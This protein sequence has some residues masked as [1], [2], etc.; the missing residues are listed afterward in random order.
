MS[1][2]STCDTDWETLQGLVLAGGIGTRLRPFTYTGAKQLLPVANKPVLFYGIEQLVAADVRDIGIIVGGAEA[3]VRALVGNGD[4]FGAQVTYLPQRDPLG[5]AHA[6]AVARAWLGQ[7]P[8][9][10]LLGDNFLRGGLKAIVD[11]F[12]SVRPVAQ[13][14]LVQVPNPRE[15]GVAVVGP[16][17]ELIRV[18][19]KPR[20][21]VS[22]LAVIGVYCFAPAVHCVI[23]RQ[24]PSARG[25][26]EIT[27]TIQGLLDGGMRVHAVPVEDCWIDTGKMGGLLEA[28]RA[29]RE[30]L[31]SGVEGD[32]DSASQLLGRVVVES[33]AQ[34]RASIIEGPTIVGHDTLV[35]RSYV[36]P[37]TSIY[38]DCRIVDA[39]ITGS[40]VLERTEIVGVPGRIEGSLIG[41]DV[42][43]RGAKGGPPTYRL[44]LG[45]QS[46]ASLL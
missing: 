16:D 3:E 8:F 35:Q 37:F 5:L 14:H 41:R 42:R 46:E 44:V 12:R 31:V 19:E 39:K 30:T 24:K 2:R 33:G 20:D 22:D 27:D 7:S 45:D 25:E 21:L 28:N 43:L 1:S 6:V 9:V 36:G 34:V 15:F 32:V 13:V 29:V 18:V 4:R 10:M 17:G 11:R 26:L 38:H 23:E 40:V